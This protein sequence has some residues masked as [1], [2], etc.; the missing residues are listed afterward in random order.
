LSATLAKHRRAEAEEKAHIQAEQEE[1]RRRERA[2]RE[3]DMKRNEYLNRKAETYEGYCR[4][5]NLQ[6]VFGPHTKENGDDQFNRIKNGLQKLVEAEGR[7]FESTAV[8]HEAID[9]KRFSE[10]DEM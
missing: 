3:R 7:Q 5:V 1:L 9:L 4:L 8:A 2:Q 10:D 6:T